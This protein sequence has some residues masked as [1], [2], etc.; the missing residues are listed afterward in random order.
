MPCARGFPAGFWV[1]EGMNVR[2]TNT[3]RFNSFRKSL[4]GEP[5]FARDRTLP[6]VYKNVDFSV[7]QA[8]YKYI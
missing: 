6:D 5:A 1:S 3:D 4:L 8:R 7:T 2:V